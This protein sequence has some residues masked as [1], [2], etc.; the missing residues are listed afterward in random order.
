MLRIIAHT[1]LYVSL[2]L[3]KCFAI[4]FVTVNL[5]YDLIPPFRV[6]TRQAYR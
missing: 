4:Q 1:G 6:A 5:I 2:Q 3:L